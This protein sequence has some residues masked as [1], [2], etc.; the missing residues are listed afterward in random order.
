MPLSRRT[1]SKKKQQTNLIEVVD[2]TSL[3]KNGTDLTL[4]CPRDLVDVL[5]LDHGA[6]VILQ[7]LSE[8]VLQLRAAEVGED[9]L[10]V[11]RLIEH[12]QVRFHLAYTHIHL[13]T[14]PMILTHTQIDRYHFLTLKH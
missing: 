1:R 7:D 4:D 8:V 3:G 14:Y 11:R 9:G 10:P 5:R 12:A 6:Q 2:L 13:V